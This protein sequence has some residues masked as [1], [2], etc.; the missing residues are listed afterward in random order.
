MA[1]V[2]MPSPL[3]AAH[4]R[5]CKLI[6]GWG[7]HEHGAALRVAEAGASDLPSEATPAEAEAV[8]APAVADVE[9][10]LSGADASS[11]APLVLFVSKMVAVPAAALPRLPG[12][13]APEHPLEERFVGFGRVFA[14]TARD[15][16]HV[17]VLSPKY[18]PA[19]PNSK[20]RQVTDSGRAP[21]A[22]SPLLPALQLTVAL[23]GS[24]LTC[25]E[26]TQT[27]FSSPRALHRRPRYAAST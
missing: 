24:D 26:A 15:G 3:D 10:A 1:A 5:V 13:P 27:A 14:G 11:S 8:Q 16:D 18:D 9:R 19:E 23:H 12:E 22:V 25:G 6:P 21:L 7:R 4:D 17:H 20:E 2:H